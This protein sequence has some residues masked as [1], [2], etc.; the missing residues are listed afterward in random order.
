VPDIMVPVTPDLVRL[1]SEFLSMP[2]LCLTVRQAARL[3]SVH[4]GEARVL[5]EALIDEGLLRCDGAGTFRRVPQ[6]DWHS[7]NS[8]S[9][10]L[11]RSA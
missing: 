2:G 6:A 9:K 5:L 7:F 10:T 4:E 8:P 11:R 3:L 1:R